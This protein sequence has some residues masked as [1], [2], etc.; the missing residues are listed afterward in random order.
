MIRASAQ[1]EQQMR[2]VLLV[3]VAALAGAW[4]W[5]AGD[6]TQ[7]QRATY[8]VTFYYPSHTAR[9]LGKA[10]GLN[11]CQEM[12]RSYAITQKVA[13]AMWYYDCCMIAHGSDCYEKHK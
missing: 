8:N 13:D 10:I 9:Y 5:S 7:I 4:L 11:Q 3:A 6:E 1:G 12:A 2:P